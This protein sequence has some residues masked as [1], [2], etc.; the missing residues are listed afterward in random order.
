MSNNSIFDTKWSE[1]T[2]EN[3]VYTG[4]SVSALVAFFFGI[5]SVLVFVNVWFFFIGIL[6]TITA[7]FAMWTIRQ[8]GGLLT[9]KWFAYLGIVMPILFTTTVFASSVFF[10]YTVNHQSEQFFRDWFAVVQ[11]GNVQEVLSFYTLPRPEIQDDKVWWTEQYSKDGSHRGLHE[12]A[13]NKLMRIFLALGSDAKITYYK[14][15]KIDL[16]YDPDYVEVT[17]IY[18]LTYQSKEGKTETFFF[19]ITARRIYFKAERRYGWLL[20]HHPEF[21]LPEEFNGVAKPE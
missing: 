8:S 6:G 14:T 12:F 13:E 21:V 17:K 11:K 3:T 4:V 20:Y 1:T 10:D 7:L 18:A 15:D 16:V 2:E 5:S 19:K 9:G